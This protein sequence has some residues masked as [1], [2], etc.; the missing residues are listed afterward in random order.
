MAIQEFEPQSE[1]EPSVHFEIREIEIGE[2]GE[3]SRPMHYL[4]LGEEALGWVDMGIVNEITGY[5]DGIDN[6]LESVLAQAGL[7]D[8]VWKAGADYLRSNSKIKIVTD[9]D[10][11]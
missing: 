6:D 3:D 8:Q 7:L 5:I 11:F 2:N 4:F 9:P 10:G 1:P